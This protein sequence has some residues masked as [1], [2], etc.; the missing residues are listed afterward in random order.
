MTDTKPDISLLKR[1]LDRLIEGLT[2]RDVIQ[3]DAVR[4]QVGYA[5]AP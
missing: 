3:R 1:A 2:R 5:D 4:V